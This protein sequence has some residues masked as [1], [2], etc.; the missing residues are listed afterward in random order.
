MNLIL[1]NVTGYPRRRTLGG[2]LLAANYP[3]SVVFD[4]FALN[5]TVVSYEDA[6]DIGVAGDAVALPD[7]WQLVAD[8]R[9]ELRHMKTLIEADTHSGKE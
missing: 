5:V 6:L 8:V 3:F 9:A 2:H 4:G 1:S 7:A